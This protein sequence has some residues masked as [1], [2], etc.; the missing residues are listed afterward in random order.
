MEYK[1]NSVVVMQKISLACSYMAVS[2]EPFEV[3]IWNLVEIS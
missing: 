1:I 3:G 2:N